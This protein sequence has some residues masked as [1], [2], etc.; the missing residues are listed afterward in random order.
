MEEEIKGEL[1][2]LVESENIDDQVKIGQAL[3]ADYIV[4]GRVDNLEI[5]L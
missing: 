3:F 1:S 4:V 2:N 5:K